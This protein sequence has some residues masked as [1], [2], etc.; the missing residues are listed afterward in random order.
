MGRTMG[1]NEK[2][3]ETGVFI[4]LLAETQSAAYNS[5]TIQI[6]NILRHITYTAR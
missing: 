4:D 1:K 6:H 3:P 2:R 5:L